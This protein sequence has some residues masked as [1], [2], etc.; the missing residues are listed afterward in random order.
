MSAV[1]K[2]NN[3]KKRRSFKR[4]LGKKRYRKR[5]IIAVEGKITEPRYFNLFNNSDRTI[6]IKCLKG[7][8]HSGP[9]AILERLENYLREEELL[10][11]DEAWIVVDKDQWTDKQLV[12][13]HSW[14]KQ[15]RNYGF[16][17]SNP[18]FEYWLLLHFDDGHNIQSAEECKDRLSQYL[19]DYNNNINDRKITLAMINKAILRAKKR[20]K[21][22]CIDWPKDIGV[23]TVYK[24]IEKIIKSTL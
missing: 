22:S 11:T 16:A 9:A 2:K 24:L 7:T 15:A 4:P 23:T 12:I 5:F 13:L 10:K 8:H 17:L 18:L 6:F 3:S 21:P 19:P 14:S 20:D 1:N